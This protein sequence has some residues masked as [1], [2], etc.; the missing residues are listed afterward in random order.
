MEEC[1]ALLVIERFL[2]VSSKRTGVPAGGEFQCT[3]DR[4]QPSV[5]ELKAFSAIPG[6][7]LRTISRTAMPSKA[8]EGLDYPGPWMSHDTRVSY[9][10][11]GGFIQETGRPSEMK[12]SSSVIREVCRP[13]SPPE[14]ASDHVYCDFYRTGPE[15]TNPTLSQQKAV[16][17]VREIWRTFDT[18]RWAGW[19]MR[20]PSGSGRWP[21]PAQSSFQNVSHGLQE[22]TGRETNS[23]GAIALGL[24]EMICSRSPSNCTR[25][26]ISRSLLTNCR[27]FP[28]LRLG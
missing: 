28:G 11:A 7:S 16:D 18:H 20:M 24:P 15:D 4:S 14:P 25:S 6:C 26:A 12:P 13:V 21:P 10:F 17:E 5:E 3:S 22:R 27:T 9:K 8:K 1:C 23:S 2:R 19:P